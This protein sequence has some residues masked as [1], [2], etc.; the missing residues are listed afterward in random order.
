MQNHKHWAHYRQGIKIIC[1]LGGYHGTWNA[2]L[3][4]CW[5]RCGERGC[6][7]EP[8]HL[9]LNSS[10][11]RGS[12]ILCYSAHYLMGL[13]LYS[14]PYITWVNQSRDKIHDADDG[15]LKC[16]QEHLVL[17]HRLSEPPRPWNLSLPFQPLFH[18]IS[19]PPGPLGGKPQ[20]QH[21][22]PPSYTSVS[23][24]MSHTLCGLVV[25]PRFVLSWHLL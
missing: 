1:F 10:G 18:S 2:L 9:W 19:F 11:L 16:P 3:Y 22:R 6:N 20:T 15:D 21:L 4:N 5:G 7:L 23:G 25:G 12:R 13:I 17:D 14:H 8:K 24:R